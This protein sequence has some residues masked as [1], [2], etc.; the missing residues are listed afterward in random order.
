MQIKYRE[1]DTSGILSLL[2]SSKP[3]LVP[4]T[5]NVPPFITGYIGAL[6]VGWGSQFTSSHPKLKIQAHAPFTRAD[7]IGPSTLFYGAAGVKGHPIC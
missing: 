1:A 3:F 7:S 6:E 4:V 2:D 5:C